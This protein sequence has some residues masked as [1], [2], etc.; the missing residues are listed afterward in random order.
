MKGLIIDTLLVMSGAIIGAIIMN[1][2]V[3]IFLL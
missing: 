1:H 2:L 3:V